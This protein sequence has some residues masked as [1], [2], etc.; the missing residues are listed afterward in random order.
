MKNVTT[1]ME[2][3]ESCRI[4]PIQ[5]VY[6]TLH[7]TLFDVWGTNIAYGPAYG[8]HFKVFMRDFPLGR[9]NTYNIAHM[10]TMERPYASAYTICFDPE[11][12]SANNVERWG[13]ELSKNKGL[14]QDKSTVWFAFKNKPAGDTTD[15]RVLCINPSDWKQIVGNVQNKEEILQIVSL[16]FDIK[17]TDYCKERNPHKVEKIWIIYKANA[18]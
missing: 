3:Y 18:L 16:Y 12:R 10:G 13:I 4:Y 2:L 6:E 5:Q 9:Y 17:A 11:T 8:T 1:Q 14:E 15:L 7:R